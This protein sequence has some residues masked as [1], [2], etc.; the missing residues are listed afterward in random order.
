MS[1]PQIETIDM[2]PT[3][4]GYIGMA[5]MFAQAVVN[6]ATDARRHDTGKLLGGLAEI[7]VYLGRTLPVPEVAA[8]VA[9]IKQD[10][11]RPVSRR[12]HSNDD[13]DDDDTIR[14]SLALVVAA[15]RVLSISSTPS[16][17]RRAIEDAARQHGL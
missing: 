5:R 17:L 14:E 10:A 1:E 11:D 15:F 6:D 7:L 8:L 9:D 13:D 12:T 3:T 2:T 16:N 4:E